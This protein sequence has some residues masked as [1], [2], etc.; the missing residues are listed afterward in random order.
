M[1]SQVVNY[2][3]LQVPLRL[4]TAQ[5]IDA[6]AR[7]AGFEMVEMYGS[8]DEEVKVDDEDLAFRLVSVLRKL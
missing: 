3:I 6:L 2:C 7:C 1:V 8:L 5:E 4:F